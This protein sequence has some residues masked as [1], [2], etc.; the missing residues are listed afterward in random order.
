[1]EKGNHPN[2]LQALGNYPINT[3]QMLKFLADMNNQYR[4]LTGTNFNHVFQMINNFHNN[5]FTNKL[6][7]EDLSA[8]TIDSSPPE[9]VLSTSRV[10]TNESKCVLFIGNMCV[11]MYV[12]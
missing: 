10:Q 2:D 8:A 12:C 11:C 1:M 9:S 4:F 6:I 5:G 3:E 7:H